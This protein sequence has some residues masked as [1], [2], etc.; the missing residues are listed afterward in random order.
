MSPDVLVDLASFFEFK[1]VWVH[2][3]WSKC[4]ARNIDVIIV[5][6]W[7][8]RDLFS[9]CS[10]L[11]C[12]FYYPR[13]LVQERVN[14]SDYACQMSTIC[15]QI[16]SSKFWRSNVSSLARL[17]EQ[18]CSLHLSKLVSTQFS[19]GKSIWANNHPI[20]LQG[21]VNALDYTCQ[22]KKIL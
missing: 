1:L 2:T 8:K 14:A 9:T 17:A 4:T 13:R 22:H 15:L 21:M 16:L 19:P 20:S 3:F 7:G 12:T 11:V 18:V 6:V 5:K 10:L